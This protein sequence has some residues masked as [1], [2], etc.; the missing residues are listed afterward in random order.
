L[1]QFSFGVVNKVCGSLMMA[2]AG[3]LASKDFAP[4]R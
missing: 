4:Q 2:A 3:L 1:K